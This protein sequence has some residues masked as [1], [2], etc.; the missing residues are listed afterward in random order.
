[1][2]RQTR[3]LTALVEVMSAISLEA[4]EVWEARRRLKRLLKI[5]AAEGRWQRGDEGSGGN[6]VGSASSIRQ[7][8]GTE[9]QRGVAAA[10]SASLIQHVASLRGIFLSAPGVDGQ[11]EEAA[12]MALLSKLKIAGIRR[13]GSGKGLL[14]PSSPAATASTSLLGRHA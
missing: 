5:T 6:N 13:A 8:A 4:G 14:A 1:M 10:R 11:P 2:L 12:V 3:V 9:K 7:G